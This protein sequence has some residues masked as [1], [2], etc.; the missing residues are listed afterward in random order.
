MLGD[1]I[2]VFSEQVMDPT[3]QYILS[4]IIFIAIPFI[5]YVAYSIYFWKKRFDFRK[6]H[7]VQ[8]YKPM[9]RQLR[10]ITTISKV[11]IILNLLTGGFSLYSTVQYRGEIKPD[12]SRN[13][14]NVQGVGQEE[15]GRKLFELKGSIVL[16]DIS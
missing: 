9:P 16:V 12:Y 8:Q 4:M 6:I 15:L 7:N 1:P 11:Y 2:I 3:V 13:L 14:M 5:L 10:M